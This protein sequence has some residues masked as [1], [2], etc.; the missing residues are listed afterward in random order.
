MR[1]NFWYGRI[2]NFKKTKKDKIPFEFSLIHATDS[3]E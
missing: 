2:E 1:Q 3:L